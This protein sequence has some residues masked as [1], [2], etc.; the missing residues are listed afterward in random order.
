MP[1]PGSR[2]VVRWNA[3]CIDCGNAEFAQTVRFYR[4]LLDL[5][6]GEDGCVDP[7]DCTHDGEQHWGSLRDRRGGT[8]VL[9]QSEPWYE[10]PVWPEAPPRQTKM[11]H[12]E[13]EADDVEAAVQFAVEC[14]ARVAP[15]QPPD[16]DPVRLRV[17]LDPAGHPFC[18][19]S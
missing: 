18:L 17:M 14:G 2:P 5:E 3:V 19:W 11:L 16:R 15:H 7:A 6:I 12:F 1:S 10:A 9:I 4:D 8:G 13:I